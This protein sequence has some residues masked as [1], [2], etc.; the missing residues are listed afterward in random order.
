MSYILQ[1]APKGNIN[2][3]RDLCRKRIREC[4]DPAL[5]HAYR[6]VLMRLVDYV[7]GD[8]FTAWPAFDTL[9][10]DVGVHR[11]TAIRA[12]NAGRKLGLLRR[13]KKGGKK[14]GRGISN[15]YVFTPDIVAGVQPC[16]PVR[17]NDIVAGEYLTQ[18]QDSARHSSRAATLSSN[19]HL[20]DNLKAPPSS[21]FENS[22]VVAQ[23]EER[24]LAREGVNLPFGQPPL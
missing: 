2:K 6:S 19:Y 9:A 24:G 11:A 10:V 13:I 1:P 21:S 17:D 3:Y 23:Q 22:A 12:V 4:K 7:H 8:D 14:K 5:T 18:S 20:K 15:R 16:Q